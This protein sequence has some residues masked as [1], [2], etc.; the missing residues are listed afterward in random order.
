MKGL[1]PLDVVINAAQGARPYSGS[2]GRQIHMLSLY[3]AVRW[4]YLSDTLG[5]Q[6][7]R[8]H[9]IDSLPSGEDFL[10]SGGAPIRRKGSAPF[11]Y[12]TDNI[13]ALADH[14]EKWNAF[15]GRGRAAVLVFD[16]SMDTNPAREDIW[17]KL[18]PLQRTVVLS[19]GM[20]S[21]LD[22]ARTV[23]AWETGDESGMN[24][25]IV[26]YRPLPSVELDF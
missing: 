2:M 7:C 20:E 14:P 25:E 15:A 24:P 8:T 17:K 23:Q 16:G 18:A 11:V 3:Y 9:N 4:F 10:R 21:D 13:N 6:P 1:P 26:V 22:V 5:L 12:L 19:N